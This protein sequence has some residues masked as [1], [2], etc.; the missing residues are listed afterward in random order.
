M[1]WG[2]FLGCN[3]ISA[4]NRGKSI[5][6]YDEFIYWMAKNKPNINSSYKY[7][8]YCKEEEFPIFLPKSPR[9]V[10]NKPAKVLYKT[11]KDIVNSII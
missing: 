5:I 6:S 10:Y 2:D 11:I 9:Q 7:I 3:I 4:K 1:G 8:Q